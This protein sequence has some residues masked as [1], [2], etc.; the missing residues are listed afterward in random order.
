MGSETRSAGRPP[1]G[2]PDRRAAIVDAA[3]GEF[4]DH[5][6]DR[7]TIRAIAARA[8]VHPA[9]VG[10]YFGTKAELF[11]HVMELP[12]PVADA[13]LALRRVPPQEWADV[14]ART[15]LAGDP[16]VRATLTGVVRAASSDPAAAARIREFYEAHFHTLLGDLGVSHPA[17]RAVLLSSL[18]VG[19]VVTG[20]VVGLSGFSGADPAVRRAL[21]T[22]AVDAVLRTE[23]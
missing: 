4:R 3:R 21:V 16:E 1:A 13:S 10:H 18:A 12:G 14:L 9:L 19:L 6:F 2:G 11:A 17:A 23:L 15:L 20:D 8:E 7:A 5:G 22:A